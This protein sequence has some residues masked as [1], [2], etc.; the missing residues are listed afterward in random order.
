MADRPAAARH[1]V[2]ALAEEIVDLL[3]GEGYRVAEGPEVEAEWL[4]FDALNMAADHPS[5]SADG[6]FSIHGSGGG[7][8]GLVLRGHTSPVQVRAML[9][10]RAPL[11]MVTVGRV[12]R[13]DPPDATHSPVFHQAEGL[14]VAEGLTMDDL[15]ATLGHLA[16]A[17]FGDSTPVR[18]RPH[19]FAYTDPSAEA[20]VR[21]PT[22]RGGGCDLCEDGWIEWAGCGMVHPRVLATCGVDPGRHTGFAFGL[23]VERTLMLRHGLRDIR[24]VLGHDRPRPAAVRADVPSDRPRPAAARAGEPL[25]APPR[26]AANRARVPGALARAEPVSPFRRRQAAAHALTAAGWTETQ[27]F[28]FLDPAVWDAFGL[29]PDDPHRAQLRVAN[30]LDGYPAALRTSLLPGVLAELRA[31]RSPGGLMVFEQGA[32]FP[33]PPG[34]L[35]PPPLPAG[36]PPRPEELAALDAAIPAQPHHL[37][38]ALTGGDWHAAVTAG[39]AVGLHWGLRLRT[40]GGPGGTRSAWPWH[41]DR[42]A[43]LT[44]DG[45]SVGEAGELDPAVLRRLRLP[46]GVAA[47][48]LDLDT[49]DRLS[50]GERTRPA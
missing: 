50:G 30:P 1:P 24:D 46:D 40:E 11:R 12:F 13:P 33:R 16:A 26:P 20:D 27:T 15:C 6:T 7:P 32:V 34:G 3:A 14:A 22:C 38:A 8:S 29:P 25:L 4:N 2:A 9:G 10:H 19:W 41:G 39:H 42:W 48:T 47:L 45:T 28:P 37:A 17:M 18:L 23:G 31:R 44:V 43:R 21:C 36:S 49:L 5:R 35:H